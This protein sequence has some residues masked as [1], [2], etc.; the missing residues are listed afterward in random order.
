[1]SQIALENRREVI[2]P[3]QLIF[4]FAGLQFI[5]TFFTDPMM[6]TFDES[7]W[8]YIG[9]NWVRNGMIPY[10]GGVDNKSPLIFY[11]FGLS[12][13]LFGVNHWFPRMTGIIVQ[14]A[15]IYY[16]FKIAKHTIGYNG[17]ILA[18]SFYGLSLLWK[19]TGGKYV[20]YTETYEITALIV[21]VYFAVSLSGKNNSF[22]SGLFSSLAFGFRI[23]AVFG[24]IPVFIYLLRS[25]RRNAGYYVMGFMSGVILLIM[26]AE[27]AGIKITDLLYFGFTDNF[28]PGSATGHSLSWKIQH[29]SDGFF[30][31]E[32][33]LFYPVV[34]YY[35]FLVSK[36]DFLKFWLLSELLGMFIVGVYDRT[37]FKDMLPAVSLMSAYSVSEMIIRFGIPYKQ[38][39]IGLWIVFFPKTLEPLYA[40]K[41]YVSSRNGRGG[42]YDK[43]KPIENEKIKKLV[44]LW[45]KSN[46]SSDEKVFVAGYGSEIQAYSERI[47]PAIY[48]NVSQTLSAKR[49]LYADLSLN[50]PDLMVIPVFESYSMLVDEDLRHFIDDL[51]ASDYTLDTC[52]YSYNIFKY[53]YHRNPYKADS[54]SR[55]YK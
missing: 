50:K 11:I 52:I 2:K 41:N 20:S 40:I 27:F 15:G 53:N 17:G 25:K 5:I 6:L 26:L 49:Q 4:I 31:S 24:I 1:V 51:A 12:D 18:L 33:I 3:L 7:M 22:I 9:R 10:A 39:Y 14:S 35:F 48:F 28:G 19:S 44:G 32:I 47:S 45:I 46:T 54:L 36:F 38:V 8:H 21:S 42:L 37:H 13:W 43:V 30:Y 29:F 23:T 55:I 34:V 16:L